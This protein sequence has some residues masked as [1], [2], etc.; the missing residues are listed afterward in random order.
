MTAQVEQV[1]RPSRAP[2]AKQRKLRN[3]L[4]DPRFQLK[5]T[6][7]VVA[8][9]V[10]V[11]SVLG[12]VALQYSM[13]Q[14]QALNMQMMELKRAQGEEVDDRFIADMEV[15]ARQEDERVRNSVIVGILVMTFALGATGVIVTHKLVGPAYRLRYLLSGVGAGRIKVGFG[16]RKGDELQDVFEAFRAMVLALRDAHA[17]DIERLDA[18]IEKA[19]AAG[20][21]EDVVS[22]VRAVRD[23]LRAAID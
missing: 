15:Y 20:V 19:R 8:V 16:L 18:A 23:R 7:M 9:T 10:V 4:L 5:Y 17:G 6:G 2:G 14:T 21:S 12:Y 11:A 1:A 3:F 13:G 22:D